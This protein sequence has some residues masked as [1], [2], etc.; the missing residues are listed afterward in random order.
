[1][2]IGVRHIFVSEDSLSKGEGPK[3]RFCMP[4]YARNNLEGERLSDNLFLDGV[5]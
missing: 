2:A 5:S 3:S 1:M 4:L